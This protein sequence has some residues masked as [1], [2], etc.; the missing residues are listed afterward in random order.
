VILNK[1]PDLASSTFNTGNLNIC[2]AAKKIGCIHDIIFD[3][4]LDVLALSETRFKPDDPPAVKDSITP[5]DFSV[6]QAH[7]NPSRAHPS[8]GS[9]ALIH[10]DSVVVRLHPLAYALSAH[11]S[12]ELQLMMI[13]STSLS[14]TV[15]TV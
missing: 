5:D 2:S 12:F 8:G 15:V 1:I 14:L 6:Q 9:L 10:R 4:Q 7:R 3:R 11:P 13:T